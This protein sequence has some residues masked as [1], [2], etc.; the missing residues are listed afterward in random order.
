M[1]VGMM[2]GFEDSIK[3][4][5]TI[6]SEAERAGMH[7]LYT[8]DAGRS[9]TVTAAAVI[10]VTSKVKVGTYIVNAYAREPWMTGIEARDLNELS[11]GRFV[12]G[13]GTGNLHFNDLYMG[14]DS[15][16]PLTKMRDFMTIVCSVVSGKA[17][18]QVRYQGKTHRI[19]W[20]ATW[21]PATASVPVYLSASGPKMVR[22]AG[23]VSDGVGVGIMSSVAF[24]RDI[25]QPNARRG[26]EAVGRDPDALAF[27]VAATVSINNDS[28]L[29]R[30]ASRASICK[31]FHPIPHPYY[32]SQLRQLGYGEFADQAAQLMP[33]GR[34]REAM[35]LV[36]EEVIDTMT[37]T[38]NLDECT[39]RIREYEG[40]ADELILAR[41]AQRGEAQG[42]AA[43]EDLLQL[44]DR[45]SR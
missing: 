8:V 23:E 31:L 12:L 22:L 36:P 21:E 32:D 26:A 14:I 34:L 44:V 25:V 4:I 16:K 39:A 6:A 5:A 18:E 13:V 20:R 33:Q 42:M 35:G 2:L 43:Y 3:T 29:A 15:S 37:I 19:R 28:E 30:D 40:V 41:T 1:K 7:S 45:V 10:N 11:E 27:P 24:V 17:K 9:A 38:G